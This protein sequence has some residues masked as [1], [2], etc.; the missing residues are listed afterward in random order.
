MQFVVTCLLCFTTFGA[1]FAL[2][3]SV[4]VIACSLRAAEAWLSCCCKMP[5]STFAAVIFSRP[6]DCAWVTAH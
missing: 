6:A 2:F 3:A 1:I 4:V 5:T